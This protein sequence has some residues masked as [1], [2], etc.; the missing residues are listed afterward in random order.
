MD[1]TFAVCNR[2][3]LAGLMLFPLLMAEAVAE[4][5]QP[6]V[7]FDMIPAV[8]CRDVTDD[9]FAALHPGERLYEARLEISSMLVAGSEADLVEFFFRMASPQ[10][11]LRIVDYSPRTTLASDYHGGIAIEEKEEK[12]KSAGLAIGGVWEPVKVTG[13]GDAGG[14]KSLTKTYE[15]VAPMES[16]AASGTVDH[17]F[18]VYF[19]LRQSRQT[20]LEGSK[21]FQLIF[22]APAEWRGDLLNVRCEAFGVDRGIVRQLDQNVRCGLNEFPVALYRAGDPEAQSIARRYVESSPQLRAIAAASTS[23]IQRRSSPTI[24]HELGGLFDVTDPKI[25]NTWLEQVLS[26]GASGHSFENRLPARVRRATSNYLTAK[27][28]LRELTR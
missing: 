7:R 16:I 11:T 13:H 10:Q 15:L 14:K 1:R 24:L 3:W 18:G 17:G 9:E 28:A 5:G 8:P 25:P 12:T 23:E 27:K 4:A 19:K 26:D 21:E 6:H 22:R 2:C 20:N